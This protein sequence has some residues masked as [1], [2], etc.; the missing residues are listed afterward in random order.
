MLW[1]IVVIIA[2]T[3]M[4]FL[5][6]FVLPSTDPTLA[7]AGKQPTPELREEVRKNLNLDKSQPVQYLTFVK[8]V[9]TG[10]EY[11]WPG[12]GKSFVTRDGVHDELFKRLKV[13]LQLAIGA[14]VI[15]LLLGVLIGVLSALKRR[16]N[17]DRAAMGFALLGISTPVFFLGLVGLYLFW[18][19][20]KLTPG[21]GF[22]EF[23]ESPWEWFTHLVM[24]W[25]VLAL[26]F[27][28][29]YARITRG[30]MLEVMGEDYIR[31]A[32]AKGI[33]E[34][35]VVT[36]HMLRSSITPVVT[37]AGIDFAVLLSSA[38]VTETVFNIP[39]MGAYVIQGV[40]NQDLP[41]ALAVTVLAAFFVTLGSLVVDVLYAFLD[42]R[43]RYT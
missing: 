33:S 20:L 9:F 13:T 19:K 16:T 14:L 42:P 10:D 39:G 3:L 15:W 31:T 5:I 43:V 41:V 23:S 21:T 38:V 37:L 25:V 32:R 18:Y 22:V 30:S 1:S 4:A 36:K 24:P 6:F 17:W 26:L 28:A 29:N 40:T 8:T 11:G 35:Q 27:A 2:V 12:F 7:F 34:R